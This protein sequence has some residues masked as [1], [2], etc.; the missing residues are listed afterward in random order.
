VRL[1]QGGL[2]GLS[3]RFDLVAWE[4][5]AT[6]QFDD[7]AD[8]DRG[9]MVGYETLCSIGPMALC[10]FGNGARYPDGSPV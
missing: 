10:G 6:L 9:E 1:I 3:Q 7:D 4:T 8:Q 5:I 2:W